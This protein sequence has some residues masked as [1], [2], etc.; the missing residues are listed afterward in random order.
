MIDSF[1]N[2]LYKSISYPSVFFFFYFL[3]LSSIHFGGKRWYSNCSPET[4]AEN[5]IQVSSLAVLPAEHWLA[6]ATDFLLLLFHG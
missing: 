6:D 5:G 2:M 4:L 3:L 1:P